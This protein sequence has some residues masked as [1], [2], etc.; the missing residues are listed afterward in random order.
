MDSR[1]IFKNDFVESMTKSVGD[2]LEGSDMLFKKMHYR[3]ALA[4]FLASRKVD[5]KNIDAK[6]L[7]EARYYAA[8]EAKK[9]T[10]QD[11]SFLANSITNFLKINKYS[12]FA[13]DKRAKA[14]SAAGT[15][16]KE[17]VLP[18][19]RT[20]INIIKRGIEYGPVGLI[21]GAVELFTDVKKGNA[22]VYEAIDKMAAG[23]SGSLIMLLG[24]CL[25]G[26]GVIN[27]GFDDD[28]EEDK[29]KKLNGE[30]EYSLKIGNKSYSIDWA[31]PAA[32]PF[33]IGVELMKEMAKGQEV[34]FADVG[35]IIANTLEPM[36]NLSMLSGVQNVI[37]SIRYEE[38]NK[39]LSGIAINAATSL[40]MQLVPSPL[41]GI[42]RTIDPT[43]RTWYTNK[44]SKL[45]PPKAQS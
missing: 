14:V 20:P 19:K 24:L 4:G 5:L 39:T 28:D 13:D 1:R 10:F 2:L 33:F 23:L 12:E 16:L 11:V 36:L 3:F 22:T 37:D 18:F 32:L 41:G 17:G 6:T 35:D 21:S 25:T 34:T 44:D 38:E 31:A 45:L 8:N 42:A 15:M 9:A 43:Q 7:D 40:L 27:G 26:L 30:Q 29:F